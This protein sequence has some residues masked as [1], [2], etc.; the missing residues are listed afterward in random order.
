MVYLLNSQ[1]VEGSQHAILGCHL[2]IPQVYKS[3]MARIA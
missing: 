1:I 2:T 3:T